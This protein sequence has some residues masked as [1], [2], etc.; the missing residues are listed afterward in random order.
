M[1]SPCSDRS[2]I[3]SELCQGY[4]AVPMQP[5][6]IP[7]VFQMRSS[8]KNK[9]ALHGGN[10]NLA[11]WEVICQQSLQ[12]PTEANFIIAKAL[13]PVAWLK[14]EDV[15]SEMPWIS[16]LVVHEAF[17]HQ[18]VGSYAV[19]FAEAFVLSNGATKVGIRTTTDNI[20][21]H[22]CYRKL[23]YVIIEEGECTNGDGKT[24]RGYSFS[25]DHLDSL[26]TNV[27][28]VSFR[29]K[30][31]HDFSFLQKLGTVF[32][33]FDAQD[34]GNLCFGLEQNGARFFV[35]YAG[36]QTIAFPGHP[37]NAIA[38]L[39]HAVQAYEDLRHPSLVSLRNHYPTE[40]GYVAVFDWVEGDSL[41]AHWVYSAWE[42]LHLP[43]SPNVRFGNLPLSKRLAVLEN[44]IAFHQHV[45]SKGYVAVD[46]YDGSMIYDFATDTFHICDIDEYSLAPLF[47]SMGRMW[48]STR[49]MSPE[50]YQLGAAIDEQTMVFVM[51]ASAFV[52]LGGASNR[53]KTLWQAGDALYDVALK[54]VS[55]QKCER[56]PSLAE[57]A[58]AWNAAAVADSLV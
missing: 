21:A 43:Q 6:H 28:G 15:H 17:H 50:E 32:C 56:Y 8:P 41:R 3:N 12:N 4:E 10:M 31:A 46:F 45:Q 35:K 38:R 42:M 19:R 48:G 37:E 25:K 26:S 9:A 1:V 34:S 27:D 36:A 49:F 52:L 47:N 20:I 22:E 33:V 44:I 57:F 14:I 54:A 7:L 18:G 2:R 24:R 29:V 23:G 13:V 16:M 58:K 53:S 5:E 55:P 40:H 39:R 11:T 30:A 51:G